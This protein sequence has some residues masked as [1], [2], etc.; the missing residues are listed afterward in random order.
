M[1]SFLTYSHIKNE[2]KFIKKCTLDISG[3]LSDEDL[4][5]YNF[6]A[7]KELRE[8]LG[9]SP[10]LDISCVDVA[11]NEGACAAEEVRRNNGNMFIVLLSESG[12]SPVSYIKPTIMA[13]GLLM[14]PLTPQSVNKVLEE[15]IR[16]HLKKLYKEN[17]SG[18]FVIDSKEGRQL[19]PYENI[20]Y[21]EAREKKIFLN[22]SGA[23][24]SF[25]DTLDN[26]EGRLNEGFAR[27]H[28]SFIVARSRIK[29]IMLS[30]NTIVLDNDYEI[31]LS[32]TYKSVFKE[33]K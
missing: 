12:V 17:G 5:Y 7:Y 10:V 26:L 22:T 30:Q 25:Y 4:D 23:E 13:S 8:F 2:L 9:E 27:C 28:R 18:S 1:I 32:R 19:I 14:R 31:P 29:R 20:I 15:I 6:S 24:Y 33:F 21:F 3:R 16:E 11:G